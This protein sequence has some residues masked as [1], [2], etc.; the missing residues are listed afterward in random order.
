LLNELLTSLGL[1]LWPF[2]HS[3]TIAIRIRAAC[4]F[5]LLIT[6]AATATT[7]C[8][9]VE[10]LCRVGVIGGVK[11]FVYRLVVFIGRATGSNDFIF[12]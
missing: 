6:A 2:D 12:G 1:L 4:V 11:V 7:L 10:F 3:F 8:F 5:H 9:T